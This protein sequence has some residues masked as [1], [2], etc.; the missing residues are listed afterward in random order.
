[1]KAL[2]FALKLLL[3]I[4]MAPVILVLTLFIWL[5]AGLVYVYGLALC[6][7]QEPVR[8]RFAWCHLGG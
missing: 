2:L 8:L 5:C 1:M 6:K 7:K 4:A 3:K